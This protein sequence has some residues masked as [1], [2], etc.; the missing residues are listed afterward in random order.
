MK[1]FL[2]VFIVLLIAVFQLNAQSKGG[3]RGQVLDNDSGEPI[4]FATVYL[5]GTTYGSTTDIEGYYN[6]GGI[7]PAAYTLIASYI[8]YDTMSYDIVIEGGKVENQNFMLSE[9][10]TEIQTV[11]VSAEREA[12][13]NEVKISVVSVTAKQINS[14]PSVGGT[15]DLAQY[16]QIIPGIVFTG[17]QGGQLYVRG[18]SPVQNKVLLDGMTIYNPF[19]S[20]GFY[21]IFETD[22]IR[23]VDVYTGGFGAEYGGRTS[24]II[25]V[26]TREGNRKRF[27]GQVEA[28]PFM[29]KAIFEGPL[30]K[31]KENGNSLSFMFTGKHSYLDQ[32]SKAIYSYV[33]TAGLPFN[34]TDF[35]GKLS[36]NASN[37]SKIDVFGFNFMDNVD[38]RNVAKYDWNSFGAGTTFK[39]VPGEAKMLIGGT[40]AY[41]KYVTNLK[42]ADEDP[43][44]SEIGGF[45]AALNFT[46][47]GNKSEFNYGVEINGFS[48]AF[49]YRT[50]TTFFNITD[51]NTEIGA[52][53]KYRKRLGAL[54]LEPSLRIQY[55]ASLGEFVPEPR[56]SM[57][58]NLSENVRIKFAGGYYTQNLLSAVNER[59][60]VNFFVGFLVPDRNVYKPGS[61]TEEAKSR[62]QS[63]VHAI[64]GIEVDAGKYMT[65]N[66]EPYFKS[67]PQLIQLNRDKIDPLDPD[68][69]TETGRAFGIDLT[70]KYERQNYYF[71]LGYSLAGVRR[72]DGEQDYPTI[73]DRRHNLNFVGVY[74]FAFK[75]DA[76]E[77][78]WE[79]SA[80]WNLGSGFPFTL[81]QGFYP[82]YGFDGGINSNYTGGN[83]DLGIIYSETRNSGRL[84][85]YHRLDVSL[86]NTIHF[87]KHAKVSWSIGCTNMY[88][89][90]NIFY[91]D[92]VRYQRVN[93]LPI[94][95]NAALSVHF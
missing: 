23:N 90:A 80:R 25:D 69:V 36:Y 58:V 55:Y 79:V 42:E 53:L 84:P 26:K 87:S 78:N 24:A 54:V 66:L 57:K 19:H 70:A 50:P 93:Q 85:Y 9:T 18:G 51:N 20:I 7:P 59:D 48:T 8:G 71:Y 10:A 49:E 45:N 44:R 91:F 27:S 68:Y 76:K 95:P 21:S 5:M 81:T 61:N 2:T 34:F 74:N 62:L 40:I 13:K 75:K 22:I 89:R 28:S 77:K 39:I 73:F 14:I 29:A 41:S 65:F 4:A 33:D 43:R 82:Q 47:F 37:G 35:Y 17:D 63:S 32:T 12:R 6:L 15:A 83:S 64:G 1:K 31:L 56:L 30:V 92:R 86:K 88:N 52:Y 3:V 46:I 94:L 72:N 16:L 38:Y 11:E 60:I 67:F